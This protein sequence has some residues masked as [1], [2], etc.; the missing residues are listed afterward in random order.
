MN[1]S[2]TGTSGPATW[3]RGDL[4]I[5]ASAKLEAFRGFTL[6]CRVRPEGPVKGRGPTGL[7]ALLRGKKPEFPQDRAIAAELQ[8][9]GFHINIKD[10]IR[11]GAGAGGAV[12]G[13]RR[14]SKVG[15][16]QGETGKCSG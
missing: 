11:T 12:V 13:S 16:T 9:V 5:E 15:V 2:G 3:P 14:N 1:R 7:Y 4:F 8:E 6:A 10:E